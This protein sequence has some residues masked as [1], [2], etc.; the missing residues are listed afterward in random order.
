MSTSNPSALP[1]GLPPYGFTIQAPT[2]LSVFHSE[3]FQRVPS[4][5]SQEVLNIGLPKD[6][7]HIMSSWGYVTHVRTFSR[8]LKTS[9]Y[10]ICYERRVGKSLVDSLKNE[11]SDVVTYKLK[12]GQDHLMKLFQSSSLPREV[13][14]NLSRLDE[15]NF[16]GR[17]STGT[18]HIGTFEGTIEG[19]KGELT[20]SHPTGLV[21]LPVAFE[22][23]SG[24]K[25]VWRHL[26]DGSARLL[27]VIDHQHKLLFDSHCEIPAFLA[28]TGEA[29]TSLPSLEHLN[30]KHLLTHL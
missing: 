28:T 29:T 19:P 16:A 11:P 12:L 22:S 24:G 6:D 27:N 4:V 9:T 30:F 2:L 21:V 17:F 13:E 26:R 18:F 10:M 20:F 8:N 7:V 15:E 23:Y 5:I 14:E 1:S 3:G 25:A